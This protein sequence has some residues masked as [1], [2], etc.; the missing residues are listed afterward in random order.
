M[1]VGQDQGALLRTVTEIEPGI[2]PTDI[3]LA[4]D[5]VGGC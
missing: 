4:C 2:F 5:W 1:D 3:L